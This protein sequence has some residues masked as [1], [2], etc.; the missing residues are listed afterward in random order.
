MI[1]IVQRVLEAKVV[2]DDQVVGAIAHGL[3][4]LAA[5]VKGD[6]D[7]E[8]EWTAQKLVGLRIFR[9]DVGD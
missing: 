3:L 8:L 4:A 9:N 2:V 6:T 1:V 7:K 5:V